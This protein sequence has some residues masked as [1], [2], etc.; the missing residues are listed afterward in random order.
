MRDKGS[1]FRVYQ[2]DEGPVKSDK[3]RELNEDGQAAG[4]RIDLSVLVELRCTHV[5]LRSMH[6]VDERVSQS[7]AKAL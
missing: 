1:G 6:R 7:P 4:E 5:D 3:D 2:V